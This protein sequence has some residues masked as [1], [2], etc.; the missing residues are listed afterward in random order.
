MSPEEF[1]ALVA[2]NEALAAENEA[3]KVENEALKGEIEEALS[4]ATELNREIEALEA[5]KVLLEEKVEDM[6][7]RY[8]IYRKIIMKLRRK[9]LFFQLESCHA[10]IVLD[11]Y[12]HKFYK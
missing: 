10:N 1:A 12:R 11:S 2:K 6:E 8:K 4:M 3:L 5:E 9:I 7:E